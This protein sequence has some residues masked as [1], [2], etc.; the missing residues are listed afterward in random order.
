MTKTFHKIFKFNSFV[1]LFFCKNYTNIFNYLEL[2]LIKIIFIYKL[3]K[4]NN[5]KNSK[6]SLQ[7]NQ[8][9]CPIIIQT[10]AQARELSFESNLSFL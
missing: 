6:T 2:N 7:P 4:W 3:F 5:D 1:S 8:T 9:S 10:N